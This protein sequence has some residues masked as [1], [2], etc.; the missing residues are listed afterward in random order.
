M[1]NWTVRDA[2]EQIN[3]CNFACEAG[4]L[5]QNTA[6]QFLEA[7]LRVGPEFWPG[8]CVY[9]EVTATSMGQTLK[10]WH[11]FYIVGIDM[12]ADTETRFWRYALSSDPPAPYHYGTI[13]ANRIKASK[14]RLEPPKEEP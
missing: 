4:P 13:A 8:Q 12:D 14:L 6:W 9:Y 11:R 3:S 10:Q 2:V 7:A 5:A 1:K